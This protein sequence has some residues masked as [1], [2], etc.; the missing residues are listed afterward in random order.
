MKNRALYIILIIGT[1]LNACVPIKEYRVQE[2]YLNEIRSQRKTVRKEILSL[3]K[4]NEKLKDS[5]QK[6]VLVSVYETDENGKVEKVLNELEI[7][8]PRYSSSILCN[9]CN[10]T[11]TAKN[12]LWL[13]PVER[14]IIYYLNLARMN[15]KGFLEK[16]VKPK[17]SKY[18]QS[19]PYYTSLITYM[20]SM[21]AI[22]PLYP[23]KT[24]YESAYC[25]AKSSGERNYIGHERDGSQCNEV[26]S[27][28]CCSYG[29]SGALDVVLQLLVDEG[30]PSLGHRYVCLG[31]YTKIGVS[32][33]PHTGWGQNTVLDF[34]Y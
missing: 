31:S 23:D 6:K 26:F 12:A 19:N 21:P 28:E 14:Q 5:L 18:D 4:E 2:E 16:Y 20:E 15:P 1:L 10:D 27:G 34:L 25:H 11:N 22:K 7:K 33:Q 9:G 30:V 24:A 13:K 32:Q 29:L 8:A 3:E 17:M